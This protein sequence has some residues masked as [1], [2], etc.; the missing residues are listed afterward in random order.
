[1]TLGKP[2]LYCVGKDIEDYGQLPKAK[3]HMLVFFGYIVQVGRLHYHRTHKEPLAIRLDAFQYVP[4][5]LQT[6]SVQSITI[7]ST[8]LRSRILQKISL[9]RKRAS[10]KEEK[11][12][13]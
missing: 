8:N 2:D 12:L 13:E 3:V 4:E 9:D 7:T 1:M 11:R 6:S 5:L 10:V